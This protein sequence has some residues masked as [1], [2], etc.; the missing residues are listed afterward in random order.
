MDRLKSVHMLRLSEKQAGMIELSIM[1][2]AEECRLKQAHWQSVVADAIEKFL[3]VVDRAQMNVDE[4]QTVG[5]PLIKDILAYLDNTFTEDISLADVAAH[6]GLSPYSLSRMFKQYVGLGFQKYLIHE[7]IR[8][9]KRLL[10]QTDL[11]IMT[12]ADAV[13]FGDLSAF[14]RDF[15]LLTGVSPSLYRKISL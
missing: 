6:F 3:V 2:I 15:K 4:K 1:E 7:R 13:G 10:E 9:A 5:D 11:K 14:N 8:E 12:V